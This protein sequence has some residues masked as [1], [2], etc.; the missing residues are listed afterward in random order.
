MGKITERDRNKDTR[1][2][3]T[4]VAMN[5]INLCRC[6]VYFSVLLEFLAN[7]VFPKVSLFFNSTLST[8]VAQNYKHYQQFRCVGFVCY[9]FFFCFSWIKIRRPELFWIECVFRP[10]R[11]KCMTLTESKK[12]FSIRIS[13]RVCVAVAARARLVYSFGSI[14]LPLT[15]SSKSALCALLDACLCMVRISSYRAR[16]VYIYI[17]YGDIQC[18][19]TF[20]M[21]IV[22]QV[23]SVVLL[24]DAQVFVHIVRTNTQQ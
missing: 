2:R 24:F 20:S 23:E 8:W 18:R 15:V 22:Q 13:H 6:V 1:I 4:F 5:W 21:G 16:N 9:F 17:K 12:W 7:I 3:S 10:N 11:P 14:L 19:N